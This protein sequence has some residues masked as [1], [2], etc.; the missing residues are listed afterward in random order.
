MP[1][2]LD[3]ELLQLT[4]EGDKG[5]CFYLGENVAKLAGEQV[6]KLARSIVAQNP[7]GI[8]YSALVQ[9]IADQNPETPIKTIYGSVWT[10]DDLFP[11][12]IVKPSRGLFT[13]AAAA[14]STAFEDSSNAQVVSTKGTA[15]ESDFY[16]SFA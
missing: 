2:C 4:F 15:R 13:P 7:G 9:Q 14:L 5:Q 3:E 16:G 8:R 10:L 6:K 11:N 1:N 12:E